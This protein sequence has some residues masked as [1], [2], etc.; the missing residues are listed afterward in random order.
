MY[1]VARALQLLS[2]IGTILYLVLL[3][4]KN[5]DIDQYFLWYLF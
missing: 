5:I 4:P 3:Y 2:Y 1:M